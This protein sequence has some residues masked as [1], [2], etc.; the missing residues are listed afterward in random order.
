[1]F[2]A[3]LNY[4][5]D[6][7]VSGQRLSGIQSVEVGYANSAVT[8]KPLGY[9][10]GTTTIGGPTQQT[11]SLSRHLIYDDPIATYTGNVNMSGSIEYDGIS[12][13]FQSGYLQNYSLN[14][15]V[16]AVPQTAT[17]IVVYDE[18]R[19]G[20][21][22]S[23]SVAHPAIHIPSQGSISITSDW[24]TTNRVIG[25][26]YSVTC[27]RKPYY[28]IGSETPVSVALLPPIEVTASVQVDVD[29]AY[30]SSGYSF[31]GDDKEN[32]TVILQIDGRDGTALSAL[33]V[34]NASLVSER[35]SASADGSLT[36][37]QEYVGHSS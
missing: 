22:A 3:R 2:G 1:M 29:E 24:S 17:N 15:A 13:G 33:S 12:Y 30:M 14:C 18:M 11:V 5:C 21:S 16:G 25:I 35:L 31:L 10:Q 34:P 23:G 37:T 20:Y 9:A 4:D 28:T 27:N 36:L 8:T 19:S 26:D 7:F 32:K 6:F